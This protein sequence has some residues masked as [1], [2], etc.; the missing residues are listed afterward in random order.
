MA[1]TEEGTPQAA[2]EAEEPKPPEHDPNIS[3]ASTDP[4]DEKLNAAPE[5]TPAEETPAAEAETADEI[6]SEAGI[7]ASADEGDETAE[8][9]TTEEG[10]EAKPKKKRRRR[11][12][13]QARINHAMRRAY[14]AEAENKALKEAAEAA[15]Q[16]PAPRRAVPV[17]AAEPKVEKKA[18]KAP[19]RDDF[20]DV[21]DYI[22]AKANF[23]LEQKLDERMKKE[24][25]ETDARANAER[26]RQTAAEA[27]EAE[28]QQL[29]DWQAAVD[30]QSADPTTPDFDDVIDASKDVPVNAP[31]RDFMMDSPVGPRMLYELAKNVELA[32]QIHSLP[33]LRALAAMGRLEASLD[34]APPTKAAAA[35]SDTPTK[36]R[37]KKLPKPP[38]PV[39]GGSTVVPVDLE[40]ADYQTYKRVMNKREQEQLGRR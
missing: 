25:L 4:A 35:A 11:Y 39:G 31:M 33:P 19:V 9:E 21:E 30:K 3:I 29:G 2:A 5:E 40:N 7:E 12:T 1:D 32:E 18:P 23:G 24:R 28:A 14:K 8:E 36:P 16:E 34:D 10:G 13:N 37:A 27:D 20:D 6:D 22:I 26:D 38:E 15:E 17:K